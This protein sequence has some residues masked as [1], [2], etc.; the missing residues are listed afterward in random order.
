MNRHALTTAL[1][2]AWIYAILVAGWLA[3]PAFAEKFGDEHPIVRH[4][5]QAMW[6][7]IHRP[8]VY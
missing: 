8:S 4:L 3:D 2:V 5:H 1:A 6:P 7:Y